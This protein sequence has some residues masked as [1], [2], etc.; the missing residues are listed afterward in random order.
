MQVQD[1]RSSLIVLQ[2]LQNASFFHTWVAIKPLMTTLWHILPA[3]FCKVPLMSSTMWQIHFT[4]GVSQPCWWP[5][6]V[7]RCC[8]AALLCLCNFNEWLFIRTWWHGRFCLLYKSAD[9]IR[10]MCLRQYA[11][12]DQGLNVHHSWTVIGASRLHSI[13]L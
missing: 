6:G 3:S 10:N 13:Q 2:R 5:S 7:R 12:A 8:T 9:N 11:S 1:K 4:D